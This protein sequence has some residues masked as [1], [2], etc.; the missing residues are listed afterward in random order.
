M[1]HATNKLKISG[2]LLGV[3]ADNGYAELDNTGKP[4]LHLT[5]LQKKETIQSVAKWFKGM[6]ATDIFL[7]EL[8]QQL[9]VNG[10]P[11]LR[12]RSESLED[13][14][15]RFGFVRFGRGAI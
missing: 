7:G 3:I 13:E 2:A 10:L 15:R 5:R 14:K 9:E 11:P 1:K 12:D 4:I 6:P 8:R